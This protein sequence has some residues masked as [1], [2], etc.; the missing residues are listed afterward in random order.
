[1][2]SITPSAMGMHSSAIW[3]ALRPA[4]SCQAKVSTNSQAG[5]MPVHTSDNPRPSL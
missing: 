2:L 4:P 5:T 3:V 1:M